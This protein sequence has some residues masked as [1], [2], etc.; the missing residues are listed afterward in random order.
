MYFS[1]VK[2]FLPLKLLLSMFNTNRHVQHNTH[3]FKQ[4]SLLTCLCALLYTYWELFPVAITFGFASLAA[5]VFSQF[6]YHRSSILNGKTLLCLQTFA[7]SAWIIMLTGGIMSPFVTVI[8]HIPLLAY[9]MQGKRKGL[10]WSVVVACSLLV[11]YLLQNF[12]V[13]LPIVQIQIPYFTFLVGNLCVLLLFL[14]VVFAQMI[15]VRIRQF[16]GIQLQNKQLKHKLYETISTKEQLEAAFS[17]QEEGLR[18]TNEELDRFIYNS[19]HNLRGPLARIQGLLDLCK[20]PHQQEELNTYLK[21]MEKC[22]ENLDDAISSTVQF[23]ENKNQ[24]LKQEAVFLHSM[25][26]VIFLRHFSA[27]KTTD[28]TLSNEIPEDMVIQGDPDRFKDIFDILISN[29]VQFRD[30]HHALVR[31]HAHINSQNQLVLEVEDNGSGITAA[32]R[33]YIF[34]MFYRGNKRATGSGLGLYNLKK[35]LHKLHAE[36]EI[37]SEA[38]VGTRVRVLLPLGEVK[39]EE[40][41]MLTGIYLLS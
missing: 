33:P 26:N 3:G 16:V 40:Q 35:I 18:K 28:I 9:F 21:L 14:L 38:E 15:C 1:L 7:T 31:T 2:P 37:A 27:Q 34:E 6:L 13:E 36:I 20:M 12:Q 10:K 19:S 11:F 32:V 5:L 17:Q 41:S 23:A 25:V 39:Q 24:D 22:A 8:L 29:A 4:F 30:S